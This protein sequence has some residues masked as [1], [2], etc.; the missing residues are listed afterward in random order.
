ME[1]VFGLEKLKEGGKADLET[2]KTEKN[3]LGNQ[4]G[5][6]V[7]FQLKRFEIASGVM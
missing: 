3:F 2:K 4:K 1:L 5:V 6:Q 7:L